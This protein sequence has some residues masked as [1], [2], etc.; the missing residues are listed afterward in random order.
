M[1][2]HDYTDSII[3][4]DCLDV[5]RSLP[6]QA[7]DLIYLDPPFFTGREHTSNTRDGSQSYS[8]SDKWN[9]LGQYANFMS[10]RLA[11][12]RR[13]LKVTGSIVVHCDSS[14]N[15]I[16]RLLLEDIYG[17]T[18]FR[19][20]IIWRYKRWSNSQ[21]API[22]SHQTLL[23]FSATDQYKYNQIFGDYSL[24]TNVDQILQARSRD[25]RGKSV[26]SRSNDGEIKGS[27]GK[28]GVPI[29]D[30]WDIPFLNPKAKE[31]VG[32]PTQKP[33]LLLE[34]VL[35]L[36]SDEGDHILDPFCGSGTTLVS[37][38]LNNRLYTGV[39]KSSSAITLAQNRL[40][41]PT[42]TK[43]NLLD[44]G[45]ESYQSADSESL[46][47][48]SGLPVV[49][50]QRNNG[51]D[52]LLKGEVQGDPVLIRVQKNS[53]SIQDAISAI[54]KASRGKKYSLL[55]VVSTQSSLLDVES[56][57]DDLIIVDS[58]GKA[59]YSA[60]QKRVGSNLL[61]FADTGAA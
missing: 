33:L 44:K 47:I 56:N 40:A 35:H 3:L 37:A 42:F 16:L 26:Y 13:L 19:S 6:S 30:V 9:H 15:Y 43:S 17:P 22:P 54:R 18:N 51:I 49:P 39:D 29:S 20:E 23:F 25:N 36:L 48:L 27:G 2:M 14:A 12:F 57:D 59:I 21:K 52:A 46:A 10:E 55:V 24:T 50:V 5:C 38:K 31:R 11:E 41:N 60:I 45:E 34:R 1:N 32:Y 7:F 8:F 4:G 61:L 28:R 53:E 58:A